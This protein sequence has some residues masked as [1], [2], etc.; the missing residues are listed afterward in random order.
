MLFSRV[1]RCHILYSYYRP[2]SFKEAIKERKSLYISI[3]TF[4][5]LFILFSGSRLLFGNIFLE[6]EGILYFSC[7]SWLKTKSPTLCSTE[8]LFIL[9]LLLRAVFWGYKVLASLYFLP[10]LYR[11]SF[12]VLCSLLLLM[13]SLLSF[14]IPFLC[15]ISLV[16]YKISLSFFIFDFFSFINLKNLFI[17]VF[18]LLDVSEFHGSLG[19]FI[20][21][22]L[23]LGEHFG[24]EYFI[25]YSYPLIVKS[26]T[27]KSGCCIFCFTLIV[28]L[29]ILYLF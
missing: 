26:I 20:S 15:L 27:Y 14:F 9:S 4:S 8:K 7:C 12:T 13:R 29:L 3:I 5:V 21:S 23:E 25:W 22:A 17:T 24:F 1:I 18:I 19:C 10:V 2:L 11:W 6:F 28:H 16:L